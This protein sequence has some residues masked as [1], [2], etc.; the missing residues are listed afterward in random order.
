MAGEA[1][2]VANLHAVRHVPGVWGVGQNLAAQECFD[3][4][5]LHQRHLLRIAQ[6]GIRLVLDDGGLTVYGGGEQA[7]QWVGFR[8]GLVG[9][10]DDGFGC[11]V[12]HS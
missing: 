8:T 10:L 4:A 1:D 7:L 11:L 2:L 3:A 6:V 12:P 5:F 9:L